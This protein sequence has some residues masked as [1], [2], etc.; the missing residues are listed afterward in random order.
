MLKTENSQKFNG[1]LDKFLERSVDSKVD[2]TKINKNDKIFNKLDEFIQKKILW[3]EDWTRLRAK[4]DD[5]FNDHNERKE[6]MKKHSMPLEKYKTTL[7]FGSNFL[8]DQ[9]I[10]IRSLINGTNTENQDNTEMFTILINFERNTWSSFDALSS[11]LS[12][13]ND[14]LSEIKAEIAQIDQ[15]IHESNSPYKHIKTADY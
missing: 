14:E 9:S 11:A 4:V 13:N 5:I 6:S 3:M 8:F 10:Q 7:D 15:Q 1:K 12:E 2:D